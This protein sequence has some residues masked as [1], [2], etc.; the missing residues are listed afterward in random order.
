MKIA[1]LLTVGLD[2][3]SGLRYAGLA[4]GLV[5][6]GH[7]VEV[8][9]LHPDF[10]H[11]APRSY[12]WNGVAVHYVGQMHARKIGS[13]P[14]RF[15]ALELLR[16]V[17]QSTA[18]LSLAALR[19]DADCLHL[20]KPQPINGMAALL[21]TRT[22]PRPLYLDCDDYEAGS[23]RFSAAWQRRVFSWWEDNLPG[24]VQGVTVNTEFLKQRVADLGVPLDWIVHV[25]NGVDL[26]EFR[27]LPPDIVDGLRRSLGLDGRP[28]IAYAGTLSL[29]NHP[30]NLLVEAVPDLLERE[31]RLVTLLI[32]GGEDLEML[33]RQITDKNL[34]G[35]FRFTGHVSRPL[36]R[37][38][39]GLVVASVDPVHNDAV[40][41]ARSPLKIFESLALGVPVVTADV[42]DRRVL[43]ANGTAGQLV[44]PG[45]P[46]SL[47]EGI[48]RL[49]EDTSMAREKGAAGRS[50]VQQYDW[51]QLARRFEAVYD[52]H[53]L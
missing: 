42:G 4:R 50:H 35:A 40:A 21:A 36:L 9:A 43:L 23:N 12:R 2:R 33:R 1:F 5:R 7:E 8:F 44:A 38:L 45:Q 14:G 10:T 24:H 20:G 37:G 6:L 49:L 26:D 34:A 18:A 25:P 51:V 52:N 17:V 41:A 39:L 32:G 46:A 15:S 16:V 28:V 29:H 19:S 47:A 3:P 31:P 27:P 30:V 13:R 53:A 11:A 48:S 22:R